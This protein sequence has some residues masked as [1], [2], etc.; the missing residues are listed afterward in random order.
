MRG[1]AQARVVFM[2]AARE[3]R[4]CRLPTH[5]P[6]PQPQAGIVF[7]RPVE[8]DEECRIVVPRQQPEEEAIGEPEDPRVGR[9]RQLEQPPVLVDRSDFFPPH[10]FRRSRREEIASPQPG[11]LLLPDDGERLLVMQHRFAQRG[12]AL[13]LARRLWHDLGERPILDG[14]TGGLV[15]PRQRHCMCGGNLQPPLHW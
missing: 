8:L 10:R 12:D 2:R 3:R 1:T 11:L 14:E 9:P 15:Q 5:A 7:C 6:R 4:C 13:D